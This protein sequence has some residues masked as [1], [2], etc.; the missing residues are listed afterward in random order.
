M[1]VNA[2]L[3]IFASRQVEMTETAAAMA[4]RPFGMKKI[5]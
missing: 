5:Y 2:A 3:A 1:Q 4:G